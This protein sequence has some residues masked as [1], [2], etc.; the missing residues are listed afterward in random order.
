MICPGGF[1]KRVPKCPE[2]D[3]GDEKLR[4]EGI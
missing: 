1:G 2:E 3:M 4:T